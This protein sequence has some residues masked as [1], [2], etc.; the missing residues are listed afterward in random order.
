MIWL[1]KPPLTRIF[2]GV[3]AAWLLAVLA[4]IS[5][6]AHANNWGEIAIIS[7]TLGVSDSRICIGES[8]RGDIGCPGFA[9]TISPT[10][11][12]HATAGLTVDSVSLTTTGTTWGYLGSGASYLPN[13]ASNAISAT[14]ISATMINGIAVSALG[15]GASPTN[16]PAFRANKG[17]SVQTIS[18]NTWTKLTFSGEDF[19]TYGNFDTATSRFTPS[20]AGTYLFVGSSICFQG[21]G[22]YCYTAI[23]KNGANLAMAGGNN[24]AATT[25]QTVPV[26][27]IVYMNGTTDYVEL[28]TWQ[29]A[30]SVLANSNQVFFS[31]SLLASGNGLISGT[32]V[33]ALSAL[34]DV[35]LASPAT[36]QVLT[37]NGTAWVNA[38]PSTTTV[39]SGTTSMLP[40]WPDALLCTDTG[41]TPAPTGRQNVFWQFYKEA[42][43]NNVNYAWASDSVTYTLQFNSAGS[44]VSK[45]ASGSQTDTTDCEG[46]SISQLYS[47][48]KAFNFIGNSGAGGGALGDRLTSGT[49][50]VTANSATAIV[51]LTTN[52]TTWGYLGSSQ[53]YLPNLAAN[54]VSATN[55]SATTINGIPVSSFGSSV[56]GSTS[57]VGALREGF[58]DALVC[59][60]TSGNFSGNTYTWWLDEPDYQ[61]TV[62]YVLQIGAAR[63]LLDFS[64][65]DGNFIQFGGDGNITS[66]TCNNASLAA[67]RTGGQAKFFGGGSGTAASA[68]SGLTDVSTTNATLGSVLQYD[69]A[70][71]NAV[72]AS[73]LI[74]GSQVAFSVHKNGVNQTVTANTHTKL[75]W[76]TEVFDTNN[77]FDTTTSRFTPTVPGIYYFSASAYCYEGSSTACQVSI[78]KNGSGLFVGHTTADASFGMVNGIVQMNGTTD[79]V[80]AFVYNEGGTLV[81]GNGG[82][83]YFQGALINAVGGSGSGGGASDLGGL[84]DV[85]LASPATG[86]VLTYNGTSWVNATPSATTVISGTTS[87]VPGWPDALFCTTASGSGAGQS[88]IY[89]YIG[90][91]IFRIIESTQHFQIGFASSSS[92][93][94]FSS[95]QPTYLGSTNCDGKSISQLYAEGRAFNFIGN[96]GAGGGALGDRLTSGTLAVTANSATAIVSLSTNGTT[97]GYLGSAQ[98]YLPNVAAAQVSSTAISTTAVQIASSTTITACTS[99]NAGTLR[100]NSSNTALELCTGSGWQVMGVG[101]PAGTIS[102]FAST[103]CPTGWSEY[104]PARGRFLRGID[105]GAGND[106][107]GTRAPGAVQ[108]D[109]LRSHSH[110]FGIPAGTF[111][112]YGLVDSNNASSTGF[113]NTQATGGA[114]TRPKNVAVTYCQFNGTSNGWNN[115][116]SGGSTSA[117]GSTGQIQY[118]TGGSFDA[119]AG[120]TWDNANSRLTATN[121]S[122]TA[123]TVNGVAI[124]GSA[125]GDRVTSGTQA[126]IADAAS[127]TII[128]SGTMRYR[129]VPMEACTPDKVGT[130]ALINGFLR[131][132]R[133]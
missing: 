53:S 121:I 67:L 24:T 126:L 26:S 102:A 114:E 93:G 52:G 63:Y 92:T 37:Y 20:V 65:T 110:S 101:I 25:D 98:S 56:S 88:Y 117:G 103:T 112:A 74:S 27:T 33:T 40:G 97:W 77:N 79:Y 115:P 61:T 90:E 49:L 60:V 23:Y 68:L 85:A 75:T 12:I 104:T 91:G 105:N 95:T 48:G 28:F 59:Q 116:L 129:E 120:L 119:S 29:T 111:G 5:P 42:G 83:T 123:L 45:W 62:R 106:P 15:S 73:S 72:S 43:T 22:G 87:M 18:A 13:F 58:P 8:S 125:S 128:V 11:R 69:G 94:S 113:Y 31:G 38:T 3:A 107:D 96:S 50:A 41:G 64:E 39:I 124:T 6:P 16:V 78:N 127:G 82:W 71:W 32:G 122:A 30:T 35:S 99:T 7:A 86:Q 47:A 17:G 100:Y 84:S 10:G 108:A 19:D 81:H 34:T 118:N 21:S 57:T 76:S 46:Q 133:L 44:Y 80:E 132:C 131:Q 36:G 54:S 2:K 70:R 9:P 66:T 4:A 14:N 89:H 109:E 55:I 51:S 1:G 130:V